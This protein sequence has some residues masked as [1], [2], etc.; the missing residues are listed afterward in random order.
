MSVRPFEEIDPYNP[1]NVVKGK[2]YEDVERYG[3]L[4][5][6]SINGKSCKQYIH[7]T[8]KFYY[9][10]GHSSPYKRDPLPKAEAIIF[11]KLDGT[12]ILRFSYQDSHGNIFISYK[13]RMSP[14]V[15]KNIYQNFKAM[16]DKILEKYPSICHL[17]AQP[18]L[19]FEL[20]GYVN[21][22]VVTYKKA[23]DIAYI[24]SLRESLIFPPETSLGLPIPKIYFQGWVSEEVYKEFERK[25][26][27]QYVKAKNIEGVMFYLKDLRSTQSWIAYK[28]KS[29]SLLADGKQH[30]LSKTEIWTTAM[31]SLEIVHDLSELPEITKKLLAETYSPNYLD[32]HEQM[33]HTV[34]SE[35][36]DHIRR[37]NQIM[38]RYRELDL[39][40]HQDKSHA[41]RTM[42]KY[43]P[44]QESAFIYRTI[45][46]N[47][48]QAED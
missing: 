18:F 8:P 12:N 15:R 40:I 10:G 27:S 35:V 41:M 32:F 5:I 31:N 45:I 11:E 33:I 37:E 48:D 39:N 29:L 28:C 16:W 1:Q 43:Y 47:T 42:M 36:L 25:V 14:F 2:L 34:V 3:D 19:A 23:L 26:E 7:T 20:Y 6:Q 30:N 22:I 9:P 46:K 24:Y 38:A 44:K 17:P 21:P 4:L 13:T